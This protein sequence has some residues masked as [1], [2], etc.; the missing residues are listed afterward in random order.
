MPLGILLA[1]RDTPHARSWVE[2]TNSYRALL[3]SVF[4]SWIL[5]PPAWITEKRFERCCRQRLPSMTRMFGTRFSLVRSTP[6]GTALILVLRGQYRDAAG[7]TRAYRSEDIRLLTYYLP[8]TT[9]IDFRESRITISPHA[10]I[11]PRKH[12]RQPFR[13]LI[14]YKSLSFWREYLHPLDYPKGATRIIEK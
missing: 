9:L 6:S 12:P 3:L 11:G 1:L 5:P 7:R 14:Q 8:D 13:F 10:S 2:G 4:A